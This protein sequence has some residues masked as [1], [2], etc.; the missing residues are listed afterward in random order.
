[1]AMH[2]HLL[3]SNNDFL[4]ANI[5]VFA[6]LW[7]HALA[8]WWLFYEQTI[9]VTAVT[10]NSAMIM[11]VF[12]VDVHSI[13]NVQ[14]NI[15]NQQPES[16]QIPSV[17]QVRADKDMADET[18]IQPEKRQPTVM[19][20][21][22]NSVVSVDESKNHIKPEVLPSDRNDMLQKQQSS[23]QQD[24]SRA[25]HNALQATE[26]KHEN[27]WHNDYDAKVVSALKTCTRYPE[28]AREEALFGRVV[29]SFVMHRDGRSLHAQIVSPAHELLEQAAMG[30]IACL[31][32]LPF[33]AQADTNSR[34]YR[35]PIVFYVE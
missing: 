9:E 34:S 29:V 24:K 13:I 16:R 28:E 21:K 33:P 19:N 22:K 5:A 1:M 11:Q 30:A 35:L 6:S 20:L 12:D 10:S 4:T 14:K 7:V 27:A 32:R 17:A 25:E 31:P 15:Q 3:K 8:S 23:T 18:L 2:R 26:A